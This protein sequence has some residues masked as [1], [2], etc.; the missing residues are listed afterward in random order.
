MGERLVVPH[1]ELGVLLEDVLGDLARHGDDSGV[2]PLLPCLLEAGVACLW[3]EDLQAFWFIFAALLEL[4]QQGHLKRVLGTA[5]S[6]VH[7]F[8]LAG[9]WLGLRFIVPHPDKAAC[10]KRQ[11][12]VHG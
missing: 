4:A 5:W 1:E 2:V 10:S 8:H 9:R 7:Y 6:F 12:A 3:V 11:L